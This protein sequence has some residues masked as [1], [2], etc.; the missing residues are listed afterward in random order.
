MNAYHLCTFKIFAGN[1]KK[2]GTSPQQLANSRQRH[3]QFSA[4]INGPVD[5]PYLGIFKTLKERTVR[6][7]SVLENGLVLAQANEKLTGEPSYR[8]QGLI[9]SSSYLPVYTAFAILELQVSFLS[10][11]KAAKRNGS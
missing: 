2:G 10:A 8:P 6:N 1:E 7:L 3:N 9:V 4:F 11:H 5:H